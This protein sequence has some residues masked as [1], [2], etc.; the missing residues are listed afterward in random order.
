MTPQPTRPPER[1][2]LSQH[3]HEDERRQ[4]L[5]AGGRSCRSLC[6]S[7]TVLNVVSWVIG[8]VLVPPTTPGAPGSRPMG[9]AASVTPSSAAN[10]KS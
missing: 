6:H 5:Q 1:G 4:H 3:T 10:P 8:P 7:P 9:D 2:K